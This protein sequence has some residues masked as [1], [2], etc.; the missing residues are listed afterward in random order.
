LLGRPPVPPAALNAPAPTTSDPELPI[1]T[2]W[3]RAR[4]NLL[5]ASDRQVQQSAG[6]RINYD[7]DLQAGDQVLLRV[8]DAYPQF[9]PHKLAP[10]YQGPFS[11]KRVLSPTT[12]ELD[13]SPMS[14]YHN[15]H[16]VVNIDRLKRFTPNPVEV[17]APPSP[18]TD[19]HGHAI[20]NVD[21][22][23]ACKKD[24]NTGRITKYLVRWEGYGPADDTW[25]PDHQIRHLKAIVAAFK[26]TLPKDGQ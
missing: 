11:I 19:A 24:R 22:I 1:E 9:R 4:D 13:I 25:E 6:K 8:A 23:I 20:F 7:G 15:I 16:P 26:A 10:P 2:K 17:H 14:V 5:E 12:V 3:R 18:M 21:K